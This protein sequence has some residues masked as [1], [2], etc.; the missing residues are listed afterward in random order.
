M[1]S[2]GLQPRSD[3]C[4]CGTAIP[5][6]FTKVHT[7]RVCTSVP[8]K[9]LCCG[10]TLSPRN[11]VR[12]HLEHNTLHTRRQWAPGCQD[13]FHHVWGFWHAATWSGSA[14]RRQEASQSGCRQRQDLEYRR[15][16]GGCRSRALGT[17][18]KFHIP[19]P[20]LLC[21]HVK[22]G[23]RSLGANGSKR[24][25]MLVPELTASQSR[26]YSL[27]S[28]L[29]KVQGQVKYFLFLVVSMTIPVQRAWY[30]AEF[31]M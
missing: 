31:L 6:T 22:H 11:A 27:S 30:W 5:L 21:F 13:P 3:N 7:T 20:H 24:E 4:V 17:G 12:L 10:Q 16:F 15:R 9:R 29:S 2:F 25:V 19:V 14:E 28:D 1:V 8:H 18:A 23:Q 26:L